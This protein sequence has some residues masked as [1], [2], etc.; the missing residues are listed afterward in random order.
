MLS[1]CKQSMIICTSLN[2]I[3]GAAKKSLVGKLA[4]DYNDQPGIW[5]SHGDVLDGRF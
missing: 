5:L 1:R 2:F 4:A 3:R